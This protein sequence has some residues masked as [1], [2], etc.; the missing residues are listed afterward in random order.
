MPPAAGSPHR[1]CAGS[2]S[3]SA[4][5]WVSRRS[6]PDPK[7][8]K[9]NNF[10]SAPTPGQKKLRLTELMKESAKVMDP[11]VLQ[12]TEIRGLAVDSRKVAPGFL[13]AALPGT[14]ADG[15]AFIDQAVAQGAV[16]I[17]APPGTAL[18][19]YDRPVQ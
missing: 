16:A 5:C 1:R 7:W 3:R 4:R 6:A 19:T 2:S 17:L 10:W 15:R 12:D 18:K 13:F 14:R 8:M 11:T 9:A